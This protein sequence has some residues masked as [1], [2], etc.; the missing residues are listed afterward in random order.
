M[1]K[2]LLLA[3]ILLAVVLCFMSGV[4]YGKIEEW[5]FEHKAPY[6]DVILLTCEIN[7]MMSNPDSFQKI[8]FTYDPLGGLGETM[9]LPSYVDTKGKIGVAFV[10]R[11]GLFPKED[12]DEKI[13]L[14]VHLQVALETIYSFLDGLVATDMDN[15]IIAVFADKEGTRVAYFYQGEYHLWEE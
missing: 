7:Y 11:R 13:L 1:K 14:L 3:A 4:G 6:M 9:G 8:A 12:S 15:D 2:K 5:M 10:D